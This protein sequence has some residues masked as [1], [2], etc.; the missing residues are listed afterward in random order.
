M[1][2]A[3]AVKSKWG[4]NLKKREQN[5]KGEETNELVTTYCNNTCTFS[6]LLMKQKL[7]SLTWESEKGTSCFACRSYR[8][9]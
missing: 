1:Q 4:V 3:E 5:K 6:N 2:E 9:V 8:L 7:S